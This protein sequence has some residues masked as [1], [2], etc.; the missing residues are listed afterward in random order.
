[1]TKQATLKVTNHDNRG[2]ADHPYGFVYFNDNTRVGY[3]SDEVFPTHRGVWEATEDPHHF[4][5]A[6]EYLREKGVRG[7]A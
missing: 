3:T 4:A 5:L 2:D 1:M 6:R 7:Y